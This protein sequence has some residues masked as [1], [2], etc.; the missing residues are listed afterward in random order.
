MSRW[1]PLVLGNKPAAIV[2]EGND[3]SPFEEDGTW[4]VLVNGQRQQ[5]SAKHARSASRIARR[6]PTLLSGGD[7]SA[8]LMP[9]PWIAAR[10]VKPHRTVRQGVPPLLSVQPAPKPRHCW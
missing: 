3:V 10:N 5:P 7:R 6:A 9:P 1:N 4:V 8:A 2:A